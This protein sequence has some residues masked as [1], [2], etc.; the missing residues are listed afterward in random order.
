LLT[1]CS[2]LYLSM[3]RQ[4]KLYLVVLNYCDDLKTICMWSYLISLSSLVFLISV[5]YIPF[6]SCCDKQCGVEC[7]TVLVDFYW[8]TTLYFSYF[9][10]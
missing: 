10:F 8:K 4:Y 5:T 2:I 9:L 7:G 3:L 1:T 6:T